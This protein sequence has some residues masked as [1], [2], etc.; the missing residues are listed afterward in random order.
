MNKIFKVI[1]NSS[2]ACFVVT[3]EL[4]RGFRK[5]KSSCICCSAPENS[6][7]K[8][9]GVTK[10]HF[11]SLVIIFI[12]TSSIASKEANANIINLTGDCNNGSTGKVG[13]SNIL[14]S[15]SNTKDGTGTWSLVG[16]CAATA[17]NMAGATTLGSGAQTLGNQGVSLGIN[18]RSNAQSTALGSASLASGDQSVALGAAAVATGKFGIAIGSNTNGSLYYPNSLLA[19]DKRL[20]AAAKGSIAI[21][22]NE[23]G[24]ARVENGADNSVALGATSNVKAKNAVAIGAGSIADKDNTVSIG[25]DK[26][27][28]KLVNLSAAALNAASVDAVNGSQLFATNNTLANT[29]GGGAKLDDKGNLVGPSYTVDGKPVNN[30]GDAI[31][32]IDGRTAD[33]SKGLSEL[34]NSVAAGKAGLVQLDDGG[35]AVFSKTLGTDKAFNVGGRTISG[36]KA[37]ALNAASADAVNGSQLF[38]T[39]NTL[40]NTLGGGAKLDDKGNLVGPSYTVDGK[41]VNNIGDAISNIDGRTADN[42]KGLSELSNSVAAGKA[43]LVQLD[44]GGNAVFSKT[45]GTDKAFNVGGRTISGVKAA[46][47]NAASADAVNGSQLFATNNTLA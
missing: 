15:N 34:S 30:I 13:Y 26:K 37:A 33:N 45:L 3:S 27:L 23:N 41:P 43:G 29:L 8:Y 12:L 31:S 25:S 1:W 9:T 6:V 42:S 10:L 35:N 11:I 7:I 46:A 39:N 20:E 28:R 14:T 24:G 17:N 44:D 40:A 22:S 47:L 18:A 19:P 21:G 5:I 38:A 36:V 4:A 32:N 16:G 2:T